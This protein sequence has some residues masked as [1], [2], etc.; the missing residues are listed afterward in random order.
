[1]KVPVMYDTQEIHINKNVFQ[2]AEAIHS[3]FMEVI[4]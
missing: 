2:L 1:M 4:S 3:V